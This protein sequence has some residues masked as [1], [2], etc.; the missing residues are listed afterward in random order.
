MAAGAL[1]AGSNTLPV[2]T[3][4]LQEGVAVAACSLGDGYILGIV[5]LGIGIHGPRRD[6]RSLPLFQRLG[7]MEQPIYTSYKA[8]SSWTPHWKHYVCSDTS[9][10]ALDLSLSFHMSLPAL[11]TSASVHTPL[12]IWK[13]NG[14]FAD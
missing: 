7:T 10:R 5:G 8:S 11:S 14:N 2:F 9:C 13:C 12:G 3:E 4:S 1:K 6:A